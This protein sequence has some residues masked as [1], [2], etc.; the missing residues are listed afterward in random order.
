MD[1]LVL[2]CIYGY[3]DVYMGSQMNTLVPGRIRRY[4]YG[5]VCT[6]MDIWIPR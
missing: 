3:L 6:W 5:C 2:G 4:V 1:T